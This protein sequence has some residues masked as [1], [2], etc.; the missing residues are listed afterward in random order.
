M[1]EDGIGGELA[2]LSA[3]VESIGVVVRPYRRTGR[4][5]PVHIGRIAA[6]RTVREFIHR[7]EMD[8]AI[9]DAIFQ[10]VVPTAVLGVAAAGQ[11]AVIPDVRKGVAAAGRIVLEHRI[12]AERTLTA[13]SQRAEL[14]GRYTG[15]EFVVE[16]LARARAVNCFG[17][18][19]PGKPVV[20]DIGL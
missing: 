1:L 20:H 7:A 11:R 15:I 17:V 10:G 8:W 6:A 5:R 3:D 19:G 9:G 4:G 13:E 18:A 12:G 14:R 16:R 2:V